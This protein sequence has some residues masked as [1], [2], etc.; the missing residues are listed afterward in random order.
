[1]DDDLFSSCLAKYKDKEEKHVSLEAK[2]KITWEKL[3]SV[4]AFQ[5]VTGHT[6]ILVG[7]QP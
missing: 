5:S 7:Q 1:M 6:T 4:A 2:H 3:E